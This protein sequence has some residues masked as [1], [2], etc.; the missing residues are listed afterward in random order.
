VLSRIIVARKGQ[1]IYLSPR[2]RIFNLGNENVIPCQMEFELRSLFSRAFGLYPCLD[3]I[4]ALLFGQPFD[5]IAY[6]FSR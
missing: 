2:D 3:K 1:A 6:P 4:P 5:A